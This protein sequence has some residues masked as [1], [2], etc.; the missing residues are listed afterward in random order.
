[1][2]NKRK[3]A[4]IRLKL[5]ASGK[6]NTNKNVKDTL[7]QLES[8][9]QIDN[10]DINFNY[11]KDGSK[12]FEK[13]EDGERNNRKTQRMNMAKPF[14]YVR[15]RKES[16]SEMGNKIKKQKVDNEPKVVKTELDTYLP[17]K[18]K[19]NKYFLLAHPEIIKDKEESKNS[20]DVIDINKLKKMKAKSEKQTSSEN[21]NKKGE[22]KSTKKSLKT[23]SNN[24]WLIDE[25]NSSDDEQIVF[26]STDQTSR[27][28]DL[29]NIE[30][31]FKIKETFE[32]MD[33]GT[34]IKVFK[35]EFV[36]NESAESE[37]ET[38]EKKTKTKKQVA[39]EDETQKVTSVSKNPLMEKL[40][41]SRFRYLNEI[42][43]TQT[44]DKSFEYFQK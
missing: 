10:E 11:E 6:L 20:S 27:T 33:D 31:S 29:S 44:S 43:Y 15:K 38:E 17:R 2:P 30:K 25:C 14:G 39:K 19:K 21:K 26:N 18:S 7:K 8:K 5:L 23:K 41:S 42:F 3:L 28:F 32:K 22:S 9:A 40:Q 12:N 13:I 35:P 36:E 24:I 1:M 16:S 34:I 4:K 37:D